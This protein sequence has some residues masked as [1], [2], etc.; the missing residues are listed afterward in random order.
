[1]EEILGKWKERAAQLASQ[2]L[3][4][5][6][7]EKAAQATLANFD[8]KEQMLLL[9]SAGEIIKLCV[10]TLGRVEEAIDQAYKDEQSAF[11]AQIEE[12]LSHLVTTLNP[13][14]QKTNSSK[15]TPEITAILKAFYKTQSYPTPE[16]RKN[17]SDQTGLTDKQLIAWFQNSRTRKRSAEDAL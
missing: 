5:T 6:V 11:A 4:L 14:P 17:L 2:T 1:M 7:D 9:S 3:V 15:F 10:G 12:E 16:D 8:N 13:T